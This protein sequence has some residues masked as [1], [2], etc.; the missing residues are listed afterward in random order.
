MSGL[1]MTKSSGNVFAD[2][3][4][5]ADEAQNL[6]LRSQTMSALASWYLASGLTQAQ[7]AKAL[8]ITQPRL[9]QLLKGKINEF[10]LDALVT[11]ATRAGM[12]VALTIKPAA[13]VKAVAAHQADTNSQL[14]PKAAVLPSRR[15][16]PV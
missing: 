10:S 12:R 3:G 11:I 14:L 15:H 7:A 1:T 2:L 6:L 4:F 9:N 8:G 13:N 5:S 16:Y